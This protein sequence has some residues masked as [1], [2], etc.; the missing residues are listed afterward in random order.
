M[1]FRKPTVLWSF[2]GLVLA[3]IYTFYSYLN[4]FTN[5][6]NLII[7]LISNILYFSLFGFIIGVLFNLFAKKKVEIWH[8]GALI[9]FL[10]FLIF[11][12]TISI[13]PTGLVCRNLDF[14]FECNLGQFVAY[15]IV[16][17]P[18]PLHILQVFLMLLGVLIGL[19]FGSKDILWTSKNESSRKRS[20]K[21]NI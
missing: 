11:L 2:I 18:L 5:N 1:K 15:M 16:E 9:G 7:F 3:L 10:A 14:I 21:K 20:K 4:G 6:F 19:I 12:L 13:K 8:L 17:G